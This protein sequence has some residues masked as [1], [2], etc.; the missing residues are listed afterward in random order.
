[1][2]GTT[3]SAKVEVPKFSG[4]PISSYGD[5]LYSIEGLLAAEGFN[6]SQ[7]ADIKAGT[8]PVGLT[9]AQ[10]NKLWS[11]GGVVRVSL[12]GAARTHAHAVEAGDLPG[13]LQKLGDVY[14]SQGR[15]FRLQAMKELLLMKFKPGDSLEDFV[16]KKE[17]LYSKRLQGAITGEELKMA[18]IAFCLP[19]EYNQTVMSVLNDGAADF[20]KLKKSIVDFNHM[21]ELQRTEKTAAAMVTDG[22]DSGKKK[23]NKRGRRGGGNKNKKEQNDEETEDEEEEAGTPPKKKKKKNSPKDDAAAM[24]SRVNE[25][26]K[27][28]GKIVQKGGGKKGKGKGKKGGWWN[29]NYQQNQFNGYYPQ[30]WGGS[31]NQNTGGGAQ[32]GKASTPS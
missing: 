16:R 9:Q 13:L 22:C 25:A 23:K 24:L 27:K 14:E 3:T 26:V 8:L 7:I 10:K 19:P 11:V 18:S 31:Q 21:A 5:W 17:N 28:F 29:Y 2:A 4:T 12:T 1:M 20:E 6:S 15:T 30:Q 32:Q